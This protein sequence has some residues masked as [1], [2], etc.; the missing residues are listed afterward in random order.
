VQPDDRI[1]AAISDLDWNP[2]NVAQIVRLQ[3]DGALD[4]SFNLPTNLIN[5]SV[6]SILV[7][8]DSRILISGVIG[9]RE[10]DGPSDGWMRVLSD[11]TPDLSFRPTV[12]G[13]VT[14]MAAQDDGRI[15]VAGELTTGDGAS[16]GRVARVH[17]NGD[18]DFMVPLAEGPDSLV[19]ALALGDKDAIWI[20]GSFTNVGRFRRPGIARL[21]GG[22]RV[23]LEI[24]TV[25]FEGSSFVVRAKT[26]PGRTMVLESTDSIGDP[27]ATWLPVA[28]SAGDGTV[29]RLSDRTPGGT[30]RFYRLRAE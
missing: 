3:P 26:S 13:S 21:F 9:S 25:G 30:Q 2:F 24:E 4:P 6:G 27:E 23:A 15:V 20:G 18:L 11:G 17:L 19:S 22:N 7:Q 16:T 8:R 28:T 29:Q 1:V 12:R 14:A 10:P 5:G